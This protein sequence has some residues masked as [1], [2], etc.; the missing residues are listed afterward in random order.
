[1]SINGNCDSEVARG[2]TKLVGGVSNR[3][4]SFLWGYQQRSE[5]RDKTDELPGA[6]T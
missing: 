1:M 3:A 2:L 5:L 6:L 4:D